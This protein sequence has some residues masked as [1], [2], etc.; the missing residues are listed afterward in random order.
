MGFE[1]NTG[2]AALDG[3]FLR[4]FRKTAARRKRSR[5]SLAGGFGLSP[6]PAARLSA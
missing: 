1:Q 5:G 2:G 4:D 6:W 3:A